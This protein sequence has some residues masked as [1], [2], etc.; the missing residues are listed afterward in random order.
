MSD[1]KDKKIDV[2]TQKWLIV[3]MKKDMFHGKEQW[4][5]NK[6]LT[7]RSE[8]EM[9]TDIGNWK[10]ETGMKACDCMHWTPETGKCIHCVGPRETLDRMSANFFS[11]KR[12]AIDLIVIKL[13]CKN[14]N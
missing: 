4:V 6:N 7:V 9:E 12:R 14:G 10:H 3:L 2:S 8:I 5:S 13:M 1:A 11:S